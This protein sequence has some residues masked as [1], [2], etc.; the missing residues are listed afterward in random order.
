MKLL[1]SFLLVST[2]CALSSCSSGDSD[3]DKSPSSSDGNNTTA[4]TTAKVGDGNHSISGQVSFNEKVAPGTQYSVFAVKKIDS[5]TQEVKHLVGTLEAETDTF[6]YSFSGL[7]DGEYYLAAILD[8]G[9]DLT[10]ATMT[11]DGF[12]RPGD[13]VKEGDF[14][15]YSGDKDGNPNLILNEVNTLNLNS[16]NS[17]LTV[18]FTL[19]KLSEKSSRAGIY[20]VN[21]IKRFSDCETTEFTEGTVVKSE[22]HTVYFAMAS[23]VKEGIFNHANSG[24]HE[25]DDESDCKSLYG[26]LDGKTKYPI[27]FP[28]LKRDSETEGTSSLKKIGGS[29]T[30]IGK[31]NESTNLCEGS[32]EVVKKVTYNNSIKAVLVEESENAIEPYPATNGSCSSTEMNKAKVG[33]CT[34]KEVREMTFLSAIE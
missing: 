27:S 11:A 20:K 4:G 16:D 29:T 21:S 1:K 8:P 28:V 22:S 2:I 34:R 6:S 3:S 7:N 12:K 24:F 30:N 15:G 13:G 25:C 17:K 32:Y 5:S 9:N 14:F 26:K 10:E 33:S 18:N 23:S 31:L 19:L